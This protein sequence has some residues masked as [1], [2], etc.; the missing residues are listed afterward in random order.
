MHLSLRLAFYIRMELNGSNVDGRSFQVQP[1]KMLRF[2]G[3]C[4][5]QR[6]CPPFL[7]SCETLEN[8][9]RTGF[10]GF[11]DDSSQTVVMT[12]PL[13]AR[14]IQRKRKICFPRLNAQA[15]LNGSRSV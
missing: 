7:N 9:G 6:K 3:V 4:G 1:D 2:Q 14:V 8:A 10:F 15:A 13:T 11:G 12:P 5:F